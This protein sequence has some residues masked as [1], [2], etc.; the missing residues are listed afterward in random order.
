MESSKRFFCNEI[1]FDYKETHPKNETRKNIK[2]DDRLSEK[3][4][5]QRPKK[6]IQTQKGYDVRNGDTEI[7]ELYTIKEVRDLCKEKHG[8]EVSS[9]TKKWTRVNQKYRRK[10][11]ARGKGRRF[12]ELFNDN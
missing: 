6:F 11:N 7:S 3:E 4:K 2:Q 10:R 12:N 9:Q 5:T 8:M 1:C